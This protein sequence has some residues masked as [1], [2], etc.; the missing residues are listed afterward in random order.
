MNLVWKEHR[1]SRT[2]VC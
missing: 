1:F 2:G